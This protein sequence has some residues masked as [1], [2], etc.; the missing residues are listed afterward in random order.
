MVMVYGPH[1]AL[2][3]DISEFPLHDP[4]TLRQNQPQHEPDF[5]DIYLVALDLFYPV[6]TYKLKTTLSL[7]W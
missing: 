2:L 7:I 1:W 5:Q 6:P 3:G 4:C